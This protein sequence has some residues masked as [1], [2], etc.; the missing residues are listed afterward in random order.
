MGEAKVLVEPA[1][2]D[3]VLS[4]GDGKAGPGPVREWEE[5]CH[6]SRT[7]GS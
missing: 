5:T 3:G 1:S 2:L 7:W 6:M 4:L